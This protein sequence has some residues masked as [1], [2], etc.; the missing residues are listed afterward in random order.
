MKTAPSIWDVVS[1]CFTTDPWWCERNAL[2]ALH[3]P[4]QHVRQAYEELIR[5]KEIEAEHSRLNLAEVRGARDLELQ[6]LDRLQHM[7]TKRRAE[8]E[9]KLEE[10]RA[11]AAQ[12]CGGRALCGCL[13]VDEWFVC[14]E[15]VPGGW[16]AFCGGV[17]L[18]D[19]WLIARELCAAF[20]DGCVQRGA[21]Q[22]VRGKSSA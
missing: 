1:A 7:V 4:H 10:K 22:V 8:M 9:R 11:T 12:R 16:A 15:G 6:E 17:G 21:A 3:H 13:R 5:V 18:C 20:G 2:W 19:D 14:V